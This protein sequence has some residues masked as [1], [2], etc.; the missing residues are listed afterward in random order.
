MDEL[1]H[2]NFSDAIFNFCN[3]LADGFKNNGHPQGCFATLAALEIGSTNHMAS[4]SVQFGL[5]QILEK[6]EERIAKAIDEGQITSKW[7]AKELAAMIVA[8]NRGAV[9]L[10]KGTGSRTSSSHAYQGLFSVL[11]ISHP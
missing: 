5:N 9:V 1:D 2:D 6:L 11:N 3:V 7:C 8:I 10:S 4:E